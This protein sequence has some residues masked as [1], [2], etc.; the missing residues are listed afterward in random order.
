MIKGA[1]W[2]S[3]ITFKMPATDD[4]RYRG[5]PMMTASAA[6]VLTY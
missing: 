5:A 6:R 2:R 1:V 4:S 3:L